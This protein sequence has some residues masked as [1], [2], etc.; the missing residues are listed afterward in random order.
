MER[1][2]QKKPWTVF[3]AKYPWTANSLIALAACLLLFLLVNVG[4]S[5][6]T[7]HGQ[8]LE[9]PDF[10]NISLQEAQELAED[11]DME[12]VVTD[13]VFVSY[14]PRG[15][16]FRQNPKSGALVKKNRHVFITINSMMPR[17]VEMP[18]VA[19]YSLRQ[20]RTVL[21]S[22]NLHVGK[23]SYVPDIATNNV[24]QQKYGGAVIAPGTDV[25][26]DSYIDL[27]VGISS[28]G[29]RTIIPQ[30]VG[31]TFVEARDALVEA[32]LN[33]GTVSY[34]NTVMSY[35]DSLFAKVYKQRPAFSE[36]NIWTLGLKV[37]LWLTLDETKIKE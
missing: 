11:H 16:V 22:K 8:V 30:L 31:Y 14:R 32:S 17:K 12:L 4:L 21:T 9:V 6:F 19:G 23:L 34:D 13:S 10:T 1:K 7:R 36:S 3:I 25:A 33:S 26:A 20:A 24:L 27:D 15:V 28:Y 37:D 18:N 35:A 5:L 2:D 29:E